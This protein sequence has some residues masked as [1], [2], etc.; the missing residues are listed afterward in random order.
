ME[1]REHFLRVAAGE[2]VVNVA[3]RHQH[4]DVSRRRHHETSRIA[5]LRQH[6]VVVRRVACKLVG[7]RGLRGDLIF[8]HALQRR[9]EPRRVVDAVIAQIR[10]ENFGPPAAARP[11]FHHYRVRFHAEEF[12]HLLRMPV[13]V[14]R[15]VRGIAQAAGQV[16]RPAVVPLAANVRVARSKAM[17]CRIVSSPLGCGSAIGF[18]VDRD[19][20]DAVGIESGVIA[21]R[22]C[23]VVRLVVSPHRVFGAPLADGDR[24][25][26]RGALERTVTVCARLR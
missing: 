11:H 7:Q 26:A 3:E 25:I 9:G 14:A 8:R 1:R 19:S 6:D 17:A 20:I 21:Q 2:P 23:F 12:Q 16:P 5:E 15:D 24:P 18:A 10:S 4:V 13:S 22:Q